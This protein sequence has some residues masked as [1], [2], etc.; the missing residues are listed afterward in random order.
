M[1]KAK[2]V[3]ASIRSALVSGITLEEIARECGVLSILSPDTTL[4]TSLPLFDSQVGLSM[5][6]AYMEGIRSV[7]EFEQRNKQ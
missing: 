2:V 4:P 6:R 3:A 1:S 7:R 5:S